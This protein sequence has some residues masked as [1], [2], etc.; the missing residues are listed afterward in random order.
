MLTEQQAAKALPTFI[1]V[2]LYQVPKVT[3][4]ST[5]AITS[6]CSLLVSSGAISED[7]KVNL[8]DDENQY[9]YPHRFTATSEMHFILCLDLIEQ[10]Y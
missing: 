9:K 10:K 7:N 2:S 4:T 8:S 1:V 5:E 6:R 3:P